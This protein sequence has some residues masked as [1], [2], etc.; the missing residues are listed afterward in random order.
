MGSWTTQFRVWGVG[1]RGFGAYTLGVCGSLGMKAGLILTFLMCEC[2][3][4]TMEIHDFRGGGVTGG[5]DIR[6]GRICADASA[7]LF[8][9]VDAVE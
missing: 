7:R 8:S 1:F 9:A 2:R 3:R 4:T 6:R 5:I